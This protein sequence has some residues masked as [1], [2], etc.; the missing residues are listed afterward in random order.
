[1]EAQIV[2]EAGNAESLLEAIDKANKQN[3][4]S[5]ASRLFV[6][7]P[8]GLY[9]LG[10]RTLTQIWGHNI[11]LV[12]ESM[13]GVI[14]K[15]A[16]AVENEGISKTAVFLS[17]GWNT[18][19]QDLTLQ[20]ALDYYAAIAAGLQGGRACSL[21]DEGNHTVL[22]NVRMLSYQDTYYGKTAGSRHYFEDCEI[23]GTVDYLCGGST[24]Y[25]KNNLLYC[26]KRNANGGGSDCITA[27]G[28]KDANG[29][30]GYVFEGCT[31]KSEC[32]VVSLGR[33]WSDQ[34]RTYFLNTL[35]DYSA[36]EFSFSGSGIQRWTQTGINTNPTEYG[37]YNTHLADGTVLTP[38]SNVVTFNKGSEVQMETVLSAE[39]AAELTMEYTLGEWAATAKADA[40]QAVCDLKNIEDEAIYLVEAQNGNAELMLGSQLKE[41]VFPEDSGTTVRKANARGGF[42]WKAGEEPQGI[43]NATAAEAVKAVKVIR[44]GQVVI[45]RDGREFN[46][47]GAE[48]K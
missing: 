31:I 16:P 5:A 38:A 6:F 43:E 26:E 36:G 13:E 15:N 37:E 45:V 35:V 48:L 10:D 22:K 8:N 33:A 4:D 20:N 46:V 18:Y 1:V 12:G 39:R 19:V 27:N 34:A 21:Q 14:I 28:G 29:D 47:L 41:E 25:F 9:D 30:K 40:T 42:G 44:N 11:A 3:A 7:I 24:V 17:R 32:P 23:H 2:V